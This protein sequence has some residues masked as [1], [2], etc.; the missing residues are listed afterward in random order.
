MNNRQTIV[1]E[2]R[3]RNI[4]PSTHLAEKAKSDYERIVSELGIL[5]SETREEIKA[6]RIAKNLTKKY[7][8]GMTSK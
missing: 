3:R 4:N 5:V 1:E 7:Q 2:I 6:I 8:L